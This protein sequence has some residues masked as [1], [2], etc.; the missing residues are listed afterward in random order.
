WDDRLRD[1]RRD[2]RAG[3]NQVPNLLRSGLQSARNTIDEYS[4]RIG[5]QG[6]RW[7]GYAD[8]AGRRA[9]QVVDRTECSRG[10]YENCGAETIR[11]L[12]QCKMIQIK[13]PASTS[14]LGPGFDVLGLALR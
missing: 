7:T 8:S 13:V 3:C 4:G 12:R 6:I 14:N 5:S 1:W 2:T 11:S 10:G 9:I